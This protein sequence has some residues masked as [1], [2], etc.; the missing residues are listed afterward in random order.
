MRMATTL[1]A[2]WPNCH[3]TLWV[4]SGLNTTTVIPYSTL[5]TLSLPWYPSTTS[6]N[7]LASLTLPNANT[8]SLHCILQTKCK[9]STNWKSITFYFNTSPLWSTHLSAEVANVFF[10]LSDFNLF[11]HLSEGRTVACSI[12]PHHSYLLRSFC[13]VKEIKNKIH[14]LCIWC[15]LLCAR[16]AKSEE[17][18]Q[19]FSY[20]AASPR[21]TRVQKEGV[22]AL[23]WF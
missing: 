22:V 23:T 10:V 3:Q 1:P 14:H 21:G 7:L 13:L 20:H 5:W 12:L 19:R 17:D 2:T 15:Y 11:Y 9:V 18:S 4:V 6:N 16:D 8:L